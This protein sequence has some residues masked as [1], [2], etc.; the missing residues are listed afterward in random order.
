MRLQAEEEGTAAEL[1][2]QED[3]SGDEQ[4]TLFNA[5]RCRALMRGETLRL[6]SSFRLLTAEVLF[7]HAEL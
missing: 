4:V 5:S 1:A 3:A 7:C 6:P 2:A